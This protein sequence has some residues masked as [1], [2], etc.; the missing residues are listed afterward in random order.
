[1]MK[2][3]HTISISVLYPEL[4]WAYRYMYWD[5]D[6]VLD[7]IHVLCTY[8]TLYMYWDMY[9]IAHHQTDRP[10]KVSSFI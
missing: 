4:F 9:W 8:R 7:S 1:M 3:N 2:I 6:F 10:T 5:W